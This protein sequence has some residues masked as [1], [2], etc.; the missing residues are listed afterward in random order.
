MSNIFSIFP[1]VPP[2]SI[3]LLPCFITAKPDHIL[4]GR[5][6][7]NGPVNYGSKW[8]NRSLRWP[9][10]LTF[11]LLL[12]TICRRSNTTAYLL[13]FPTCRWTTWFW[14]TTIARTFNMANKC[15]KGHRRVER[16][17]KMAPGRTGKCQKESQDAILRLRTQLLTERCIH[18]AEKVLHK[19]ERKRYNRELVYYY[20]FTL[21]TR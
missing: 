13:I 10:C 16:K 3:W 19:A 21:N 6:K 8:R 12:V 2:S 17:R 14:I 7:C 1:I 20:F 4:F 18:Q 11:C 15:K 9:T 5:S